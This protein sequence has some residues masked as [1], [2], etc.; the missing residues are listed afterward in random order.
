MLLFLKYSEHLISRL[1]FLEDWKSYI[2]GDAAIPEV[3]MVVASMKSDNTSWLHSAFPDWEKHIYVTDDPNA[4]LTVPAN[5][6]REGMVYL[7]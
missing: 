6:G 7:T 4:T 2:D 1:S 3:T 5:K